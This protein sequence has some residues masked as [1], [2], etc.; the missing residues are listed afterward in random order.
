MIGFE[1][2]ASAL[3]WRRISQDASR[4]R[5]HSAEQ[6]GPLGQ[7]R[8]RTGTSRLDGG[9]AAVALLSAPHCIVA[10]SRHRLRAGRTAVEVRP[11]IEPGARGLQ[12]RD[13]PLAQRTERTL[14]TPTRDLHIHVI[15]RHHPLP[16]E[17]STRVSSAE[18]KG[19]E[20]LTAIETAVSAFQ[21]GGRTACP[22]SP[23]RWGDRRDSN[24]LSQGSQPC[25]APRC[26][27]T[28]RSSRRD[29]NS[30]SPVPQTGALATRPLLGEAPPR[31]AEHHANER[32][33]PGAVRTCTSSPPVAFTTSRCIS[34]GRRNRTDDSCFQGTDDP[35]STVPVG[36]ALPPLDSNEEPS[37][38]EPDAT[39]SCARRECH[40][41]RG[42][43][44][45]S[46]Q[47]GADPAI[48][49]TVP[50]HRLG[51]IGLYRQPSNVGPRGVEPRCSV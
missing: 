46:E 20:P 13:F 10:A 37:G 17:D 3:P 28:P 35:T 15:V 11:G 14:P 4:A 16:S 18:R 19:V 27:R 43:R 9:R 50:R 7:D 51:G 36:L 47:V 21:T 49:S 34:R 42:L 33:N 8:N 23:T 30:R 1:P 48:F 39:T 45:P 26:V 32:L 29:L 22:A 5:G 44:C 2:T 25:R 38:S 6:A 24:P 40:C 41:E 31:R 12:P